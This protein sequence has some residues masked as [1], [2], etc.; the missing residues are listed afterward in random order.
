V[1]A[2]LR[3]FHPEVPVAAAVRLLAQR[4]EPD[5]AVAAKR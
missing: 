2:V 4:D 3:E 1:L 5:P